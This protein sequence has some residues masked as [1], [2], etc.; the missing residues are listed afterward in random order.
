MKRSIENEIISP[1]KK[2]KENRIGSVTTLSIL[3]TACKHLHPSSDKHTTVV[4]ADVQE[5]KSFLEN[6]V[7]N[8]VCTEALYLCGQPGTGKTT[9]VGRC[10]KTIQADFP[11][12]L[13]VAFVN[14]AHIQTATL[15]ESI[16]GP[17]VEALQYTGKRDSSFIQRC[18][19]SVGVKS[20][21]AEKITVLV[22][23]EIDNLISSA[24]NK[25][26]LTMLE[27]LLKWSVDPTMR[28]CLIGI[29]N[30]IQGLEK[31]MPNLGVKGN[32]P[33]PR[34]V[35]F[36]P[37]TC[38][39]LVL[40]LKDRV[41]D[42]FDERA[43]EF[44]GRKVSASSGDARR[45]LELAANAVT[46]CIDSLTEKE[47]TKRAQE[48]APIAL[49][50]VVHVMKAVRECSGGKIQDMIAA[51]TTSCKIVLCV[52]V[53]INRALFSI[54]QKPFNK[55]KSGYLLDMCKCAA[56]AGLMENLDPADFL[57]LLETLG[58]A[59]LLMLGPDF[60]E[61]RQRGDA[62]N[63]GIKVDV[64]LEDVECALEQLFDEQPFYSKIAEN[65]KH[66]VKS[67]RI[68]TIEE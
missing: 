18:L 41:G 7:E 15:Q 48:D 6:C 25:Q 62:R 54:S 26:A 67:G 17:I 1:P 22:I 60:R 59:S 9:A 61:Q 27:K 32:A 56:S 45:A 34:T 44:I 40:I 12:S 10:L 65:V 43:L 55:M 49:V 29:A 11:R 21:N 50:K 4:S 51:Q 57:D 19:A 33:N 24:R 52:A 28:F 66:L 20:K 8:L 36:K 47:K 14:A 5:V 23:D 46:K 38:S 30:K 2:S 68:I 31:A 64:Q 53:Q 35:V 63:I 42:V 39:E 37:Y 13:N 58:D 16:F 3:E